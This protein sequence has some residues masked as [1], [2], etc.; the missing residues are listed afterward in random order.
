MLQNIGLPEIV[1]ILLVLLIFFGPSYLTDLARQL[2]K[3]GKE[4]KNINKEYK[5]TVVELSQET[6]EENKQKKLINKK[7]KTKGGDN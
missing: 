3:A 7:N 2:G 6:P 1:V 5:E 4:L